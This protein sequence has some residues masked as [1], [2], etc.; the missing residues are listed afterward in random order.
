MKRRDIKASRQASRLSLRPEVHC[1][2]RRIYSFGMINLDVS[3]N[4]ALPAFIRLLS[5]TNIMEPELPITKQIYRK[6]ST[7]PATE[8]VSLPSVAF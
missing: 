2:T 5:L 7:M 1:I 8:G 6:C 3:N 4:M